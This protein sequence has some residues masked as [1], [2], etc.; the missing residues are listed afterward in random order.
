MKVKT[1]LIVILLSQ[2]PIS[3]CFRQVEI[4]TLLVVGKYMVHAQTF[5]VAMRKDTF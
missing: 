2:L 4:I 3:I 1:S 5:K